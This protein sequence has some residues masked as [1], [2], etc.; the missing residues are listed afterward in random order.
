MTASLDAVIRSL[1]RNMEMAPRVR[2]NFAR[3]VM[4]T[5]GTED[6]RI[7]RDAL[8]L[9]DQLAEGSA[10]ALD[11]INNAQACRDALREI[12][13]ALCNYVNGCSD[14]FTPVSQWDDESERNFER[15]VDAYRSWHERRDIAALTDPVT[16][17]AE[18]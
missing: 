2:P 7:A 15:L 5:S 14:P 12:D 4:K 11:L 13:E 16:H 18:D 10:I 8:S 6:E 9:V 3:E 17:S 1:R